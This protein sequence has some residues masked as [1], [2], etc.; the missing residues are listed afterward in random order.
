MK[1]LLITPRSFASI[2]KSPIEILEKS[3]FELFLNKTGK[4]YDEGKMKEL[5]VDVDAVII[6]T[7]P[8]NEEVLKK[9]KKLKFISKYGVGVDN[10][11][12]NFAQKKGIKVANTPYSNTQSVGELV[13]AFIFAL[14]RRLVEADKRTK[15][16]YQGKVVGNTVKGKILGILGLGNIGKAVAK[17]ARGL[18][19]EVLANDLNLDKEFAKEHSLEYVDFENL[20]RKSD[21]ISCH[22]PL[23]SQTKNIIS[24]EEIKRM[25]SGVFIINTSRSGVIDEESILNGIKG[26]KISGAALDVFEEALAEKIKGDREL[27]EKIILSPHMGAHTEEAINDMGTQAARNVIDF[28]G[29]ENIK[30]LVE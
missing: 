13:I 3:G 16:N 5:I 14:S 1:K 28:F 8:L 24:R 15:S 23:N 12:L 20:I 27:D 17:M 29:G 30:N 11:D 22:L 9:A 6:G 10:I 2:S 4:S 25:K 19:M 21:Y 26:K 7:D 18:E